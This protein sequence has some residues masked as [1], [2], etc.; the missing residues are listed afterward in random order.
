MNPS[1]CPAVSQASPTRTWR[2]PL[3][4]AVVLLLI[5]AAGWAADPLNG[6][7][8]DD[9]Q[10]ALIKRQQ[11]ADE[12]TLQ[13]QQ[14]EQWHQIPRNDLSA[15]RALDT[16]Q[17]QQTQRLEQINARQLR[18]FDAGPP[19]QPPESAPAR[20]WRIEMQK[21]FERQRQIELQRAR[22]QWEQFK[23]ETHLGGGKGKDH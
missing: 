14:S 9:V 5:V 17:L 2:R 12:L 4:I 22:H 1:L 8:R 10:R 16:L 21:R 11:R 13:L 3:Q 19:Q 6:D 7:T 18:Q 23:K 20:T 15:R